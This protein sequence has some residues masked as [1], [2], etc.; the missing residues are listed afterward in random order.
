MLIYY[1]T[2]TPS[3][4]YVVRSEEFDCGIMISASHNPYYDNGIKIINGK[5]HKLEATI[6]NLIEQYI[7]A[8]TDPIPLATK[9]K[10]GRTIDYSMGRN[11]YI[12]YLMSIPTRAF[13][14]IKVGLDCANG[15]SSAIAKSVFDALGAQTYVINNQPDGLN[16]NTNCGSTP[17]LKF[18]RNM[19]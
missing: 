15:S 4:S 14:D 9:D 12:G 18:Y 10:I 11:R 5:G 3:V 16:I 6:E 17:N 13:K 8:L 1:I 19:L 2:T 7:D